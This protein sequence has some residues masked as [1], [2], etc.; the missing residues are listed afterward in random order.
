MS[1]Q[2]ALSVGRICVIVSATVNYGRIKI[3]KKKIYNVKDPPS[4][5][6]QKK[7]G[8]STVASKI[9]FVIVSN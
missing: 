3:M 5:W 1:L 4:I 7:G 6:D 8:E 2:L 9:V